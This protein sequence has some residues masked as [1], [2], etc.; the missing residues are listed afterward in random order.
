MVTVSGEPT[1]LNAP[2]LP[3]GTVFWRAHLAGSTTFSPVWQLTVARHPTAMLGA[4]AGHDH[5]SERRWARG[6]CDRGAFGDDRRRARACVLRHGDGTSTTPSLSLNSPDSMAGFGT[7]VS[8]AGDVNGDGFSDL[9]V[10]APADMMSAGRVFVY[11]GSTS[12]VSA[13]PSAT[14]RAGSTARV[15]ISALS[16]SAGSTPTVTDSAMSRSA[17]VRPHACMCSTDRRAASRRTRVICSRAVPRRGFGASVG[18]GDFDGDMFDDLAIGAPDGLGTVYVYRAM[19]GA[20]DGLAAFASSTPQTAVGSRATTRFRFGAA[21]SLSSDLDGDGINDL[22]VGEPGANGGDGSV[23]G[24]TRRRADASV[25]VRRWRERPA[26]RWA[27][28]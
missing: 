16:Q 18:A 6:R 3:Q 19:A 12:G 7:V 28:C 25:V 8:T 20:R 15:R 1:F 21:V 9:L 14:L 22:L 13:S 10:T 23:R 27:P 24:A 4:H 11:Y 26:K 17:R 2:S 5:G